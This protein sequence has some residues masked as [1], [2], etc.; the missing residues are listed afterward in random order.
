MILTAVSSSTG[1]FLSASP[2]FFLPALA[3]LGVGLGFLPEDAAFRLRLAEDAATTSSSSSWLWWI[4]SALAARFRPETRVGAAGDGE[5]GAMAG[6]AVAA[7]DA[8]LSRVGRRE[9]GGYG[10]E[11]SLVTRGSEGA[12][13]TAQVPIHRPPV[14]REDWRPWRPSQP[15][16]AGARLGRGDRQHT[17]LPP[18]PATSSYSAAAMAT[19]VEARTWAQ[20]RST[21]AAAAARRR[22]SDLH[23]RPIRLAHPSSTAIGAR[24]WAWVPLPAGARAPADAAESIVGTHEDCLAF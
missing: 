17:S 6:D 14:G 8:M 2:F 3:C 13:R 15:A 9:A 1:S 23:A 10:F 20:A 16:C 11:F 5:L 4:S 24:A 19:R 21:R 7:A 22:A 18:R 12:S